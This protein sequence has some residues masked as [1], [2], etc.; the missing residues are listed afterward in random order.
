MRGKPLMPTTPRKARLLLKAKKAKVVRRQPFTIQLKYATGEA[1]Q[2]I[3]LGI[4]SGYAAVGYAAITDKIELISGEIAMRTDI[5]DKLIEKRQYRRGR[6]KRLWYRIPKF[7][8][9]VRTEILQPSAKQK[10][11]SHLR[12]IGMI[13]GLLPITIVVIE[14]SSF[15]P[16]KM[17]NPEISGIEYQQGEL[18]GYEIRE[19]LV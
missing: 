6:R 12:L 14:V 5:S 7:K 9:R 19:Y 13:K 4:D 1:K 8:N 2:P 16:Q 15:D 10:L 17:I 3:T 18:Q 11:E